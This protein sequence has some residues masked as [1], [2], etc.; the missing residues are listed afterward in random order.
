MI[1]CPHCSS[2]NYKSNGGKYTLSNGQTKRRF[3]CKDCGGAFTQSDDVTYDSSFH[4]TQEEVEN[5]QKHKRLII[6]SAANNTPVHEEFFSA[7]ITYKEEHDAELVVIPVRTNKTSAEEVVQFHDESGQELPYDPTI[8]GYLTDN[9]IEYPQYNLKLLCS[10]KINSSIENPLAGLDPISMGWNLIVGHPQVQL[11]TLPRVHEVYP[12]IMTT[13]GCVTLKNYKNTKTGT[14]AD[15]NHS[16]AAV[17][18]EFDEGNVLHIRHLNFDEETGCFYDLDRAYY[19]DGYTEALENAEAIITGDEHV[20]FAD[21]QVVDATYGADGLVETLK[22][23]YIVRHD[24]LDSYT[25]SHHHKKDSF[26][27]YHK[28]SWGQ[29]KL[30]EELNQ[31]I[32]FLNETTPEYSKSVIIQSNHNEHIVRWLNECDPKVELWNAKLYH[33]LM[34]EML[35]EI[36]ST[37]E[38]PDPFELYCKNSERFLGDTLNENISFLGRNEEFKLHNVMLGSHGDIGNNGVRGSRKQ[39]SILPTKSV[40]GHSHSPGIEKGCYQVGTSSNLRLGY[41]VGASS[42]HHA[43]CVIYPNGKRQLIF[44]NYGKFRSNS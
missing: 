9:S 37:G 15:F 23:K 31:A 7:L 14:K 4:K 6:T 32:E 16:Y 34:W 44:I 19:R 43:H 21:P 17:V 29:N 36:D 35:E 26:L 5:I 20:M 11:K 12:A 42:W 22:P 25:F 27:Q 10:L 39:F 13:T 41:N 1:Q 28:Y 2:S 33:Y 24:V 8:L 40:I 30:T 3:K 38:T 18:I